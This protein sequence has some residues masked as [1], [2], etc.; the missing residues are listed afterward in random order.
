MK[1]LLKNSFTRKLILLAF[2]LRILLMP[3]YY[4]P[5]I[6]NH[7]FHASFLQTGVI[8]IYK[9]LAANKEK[10]TIKEDFN[11]YPLT[12]FILGGFK[13]IL[14][15]LLGNGFNSWVSDASSTSV[16][17]LQVFRYLFVLKLPYLIFDFLI[18]W[19][20]TKFFPDKAKGEKVAL[21]WLLN[22]F[23]LWII[24]A[25]SNFDVI[26][27]FFTLLSLYLF[28][29]NKYFFSALGLG[30]ACSIKAYPFLFL[31]FYLILAPRIKEKFT[32]FFTTLTVFM[33]TTI[34]F[35]SVEFE[36]AALVSGLTTRIFF[37]GVPIGF[38]ET[39]IPATLSLVF[40]YLVCYVSGDKSELWRYCFSLLVLLFSFIHFHTSWLL[41]IM[42]FLVIIWVTAEKRIRVASFLFIFII[43][44]IPLF[45]SDRSMTFGLLSAISNLYS[46]VPIPSIVVQKFYDTQIFISVLH[47]AATACGLITI[48]KLLNIKQA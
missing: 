18:A 9:Y 15:P 21:V 44:L 38:G 30:L 19:L 46:Q 7:Y 39:I 17:N 1:D 16:E 25:Y 13:V 10:L 29:K 12:Y 3:F 36:K 48:W 43:F 32:I 14:S 23:S 41:W 35:L 5:D 47:S 26:I 4:Q 11:Y 34:P 24:Y 40:I 2:L 22:P 42:P 20:L 6:R 8:D 27:V 28:K 45:Y 31:P 37:P 33:A